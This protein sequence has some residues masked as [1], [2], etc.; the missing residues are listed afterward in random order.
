MTARPAALRQVSELARVLKPGGFM[1]FTVR[2]SF[3]EQTEE[4]WAREM[5]ESGME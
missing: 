5:R 2:P 4:S 1:C 3:Y